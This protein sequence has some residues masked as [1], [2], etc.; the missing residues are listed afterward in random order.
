LRD[1]LQTFRAKY[2]TSRIWSRKNDGGDWVDITNNIDLIVAK[3]QWKLNR[4]NE[5]SSKKKSFGIDSPSVDVQKKRKAQN[6]SNDT[7]ILSLTRVISELQNERDSYMRRIQSLENE[8]IFLKWRLSDEHQSCTYDCVSAVSND[9]NGTALMEALD[10]PCRLGEDVTIHVADEDRA[11]NDHDHSANNVEAT[12]KLPVRDEM[13]D[14][15]K[16]EQSFDKVSATA[17]SKGTILSFP[18]SFRYSDPSH[19]ALIFSMLFAS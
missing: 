12:K 15:H 8:I 2:P 14:I 10:H 13:S 19:Y 1:I 9:D 4:K 16:V 6:E 7:A 5:T 17:N 18:Y 3:L 11:E